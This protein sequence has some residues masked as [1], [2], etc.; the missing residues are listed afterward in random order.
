MIIAISH[1]DSLLSEYNRFYGSSP[2][3]LEPIKK[4]VFQ[5]EKPSLSRAVMDQPIWKL[6]AM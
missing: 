5:S 6:N 4:K 2:L 3:L 1:F